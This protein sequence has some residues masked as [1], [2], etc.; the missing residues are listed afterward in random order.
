MDMGSGDSNIIHL[1]K[2]DVSDPVISMRI[3]RGGTT[4][5]S[6]RLK[7]SFLFFCAV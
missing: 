5:I 6:L 3:V 1:A 2:G 4:T 7:F